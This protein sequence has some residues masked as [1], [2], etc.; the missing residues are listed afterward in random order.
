MG[1]GRSERT[2]LKAFLV[3]GYEGTTT[4]AQGPRFSIFE[5]P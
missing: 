3:T 5:L 2:L 1:D 4:F